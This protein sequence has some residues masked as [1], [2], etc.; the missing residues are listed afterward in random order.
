MS[1]INQLSR[2]ITADRKAFREMQ[3]ALNEGR[4]VDGFD[5]LPAM[6]AELLRM[7]EALKPKEESYDRMAISWQR[8]TSPLLPEGTPPGDE[9]GGSASWS[10]YE[11]NRSVSGGVEVLPPPANGLFSLQ[12]QQNDRLREHFRSDTVSPEVMLTGLLDEWLPARG[13]RYL[14]A[15]Q[16]GTGVQDALG[17]GAER[18]QTAIPW[19]DY[20][21][22]PRDIR[23]ILGIIPRRMFSKSPF[24]FSVQVEKVTAATVNEGSRPALGRFRT[25][26]P[27]VD[28][29][30]VRSLV[31][32]SEDALDS[33]PE[34]EG[35]LREDSMYGVLDELNEQ[36][37]QGDATAPNLT[38]FSSPRAANTDRLFNLGISPDPQR[39]N[40]PATL[41]ERIMWDAI[42][43][44]EQAITFT[45]DSVMTHVVVH[46]DIFYPA[47]AEYD[48]NGGGWI[49]SNPANPLAMRAWGTP[50]I[51]SSGFAGN[52]ADVPAMICG[53]F[54]RYSMLGTMGDVSIQIGWDDTG[55]GDYEKTIR[56]SIRADLV[57]KR[58]QAFYIT[59]WNA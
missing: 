44:A 43:R 54:S 52:A 37:I 36:I 16:E 19:D 21:G 27:I 46:P 58:T 5:D 1:R 51:P 50:I 38:G 42:N 12:V 40:P 29:R 47:R 39:F 4:V 15:V 56:A 8:D 10:L 41:Q 59:T 2:E 26:R 9:E 20:T 30:R 11:Y 31:E 3:E 14:R 28:L 53:D 48:D 13:T 7:D 49:F 17:A 55:F 6:D 24:N 34:L 32:V 18:L 35:Y 25:N 45:G 57:I 23:G 33:T 22:A